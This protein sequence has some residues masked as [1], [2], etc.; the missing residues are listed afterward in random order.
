MIRTF[1]IFILLAAFITPQ[2][3]YAVFNLF[4]LSGGDADVPQEYEDYQ[5]ER[6]CMAGLSGGFNNCGLNFNFSLNPYENADDPV[7]PDY[8]MRDACFKMNEVVA[9]S[10]ELR[11]MVQLEGPFKLANSQ[12]G[13]DLSDISIVKGSQPIDCMPHKTTDAFSPLDLNKWYLVSLMNP[14]KSIREPYQEPLQDGRNVHRGNPYRGG[15]NPLRHSQRMVLPTASVQSGCAP[16][17]MVGPIGS[18]AP[19]DPTDPV[20]MRKE[21]DNCLNQYILQHSRFIR[22]IEDPSGNYFGTDV[23]LCQPFR[24]EVP[25]TRHELYEYLPTEYIGVAWVKLLMDE[26]FQLRNKPFNP[27]TP[28]VPFSPDVLDSIGIGGAAGAEPHYGRDTGVRVSK[29]ISVPEN[30]FGLITVEDLTE[31]DNVNLH[32]EKIVDPSHPFTPRW[33]FQLTDR[34]FSTSTTAYFANPTNSVRCADDFIVDLLH[35]R[36]TYFETW[37]LTKIAINTACFLDPTTPVNCWRFFQCTSDEPCCATRYDGRNKIP[38]LFCGP[39]MKDLCN[40]V[41]RPVTGVN[42]LKMR[43]DTEENFPNGVPEGYKFSDYF[44]NHRPYMRCWDSNA[45]CGQD[46]HIFQHDGD[47][48]LYPHDSTIGS[49]YAIMG[50][51][52]E[53]ENCA[54]GG[55]KG[56]NVSNPDPI[57][58]WS[59][60]KLYYVRTMRMGVKC[61]GQETKLFKNLGSEEYVLNRTG[62]TLHKRRPTGSFYDNDRTTVGEEGGGLISY[63]WPLG[64]R[65]YVSDPDQDKRFPELYD[66]VSYEARGLDRAAPGDVLIFDKDVVM[67]GDEGT[68]RNPY[69]AVVENVQNDFSREAAYSQVVA[70]EFDYVKAVAHNHGKYVDACGNTDDLGMGEIFTMYKQALPPPY[71]ELLAETGTEGEDYT[72]T[73]DDP[74]MSACIEP[75]WND[76]KRFKIK[77]NLRNQ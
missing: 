39:S 55:G 31:N 71:P 16:D 20:W 17:I 12:S 72:S 4:G 67:R 29:Q 22:D 52:R 44:G 68:W 33:D 8:R 30:N 2:P 76:I 9:N 19:G 42:T 36:K 45:E 58:S 24:L 74:R 57:S 27:P 41:A 61:I 32:V 46:E 28:I 48:Y 73:C 62:V 70:E 59:E 50:A 15:D 47:D 37:I 60:L 56:I 1:V 11:E 21:L 43:E 10:N 23:G 53:G 51:G 40:F 64:W 7:E 65:G 35:F 77:G 75:L 63:Y 25:P 13:I 66:N 38:S 49:E 18:D 54:I 3:G 69:V 26:S 14:D 6:S 34:S 5:N